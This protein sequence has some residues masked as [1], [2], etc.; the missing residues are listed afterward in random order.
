MRF[1]TILLRVII[2]L[3]FII[4]VTELHS[5][6]KK[7]VAILDFTT[8]NAPGTYGRAVRNLFEIALYKTRAVDI[9]ER[10]QMEKILKEQG[11]Q[12]SGCADSSCAVEIGKILSAD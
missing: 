2:I 6:E 7:R 5:A 1:I 9:L 4:P 3:V 12:L 11:F 10:N 8:D